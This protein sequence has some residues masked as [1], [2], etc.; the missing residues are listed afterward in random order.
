M[1]APILTAFN[2]QIKTP[3]RGGYTSEAQLTE[4]RIECREE[5]EDCPFRLI[6]KNDTLPPFQFI[7]PG[8]MLGITSW[9]LY[10]GPGSGAT[11]VVDLTSQI[12]SLIKYFQTS[13]SNGFRKDYVYYLGGLLDAV[14]A[15]GTYYMRIVSG[16]VTYLW[17]PIT[18]VCEV[19]TENVLPDLLAGPFQSE[20]NP[21]GPWIYMGDRNLVAI[22]A[23]PGTPSNPAW[24]F[25]GSNV[26]NIGDDSL[27]QYTGGSWFQDLS[28]AAGE[29]FDLSSGNFYKFETTWQGIPPPVYFSGGSMC[30]RGT[31]DFP[32]GYDL[33]LFECLEEIGRF[34]VTVQG[35]EAGSVLVEINDTGGGNVTINADG[36]HS[37]TSYVGNG[38]LLEFNPSGGFDACVTAIEGFCTAEMNQCFYRLDWSNCGSIG[39]TFGGDRFTHSMYFEQAVYPVRPA[40]EVTVESKARNDG[41]KLE[42]RRRRETTWMLDL[43]LVPWFLADALADLPLYDAVV[44]NP[45]GGGQDRLSLVRVS[46]EADEEFAECFHR[47]VITFQNESATSAC[48]DDFDPPCRTSCVEARGFTSHP[49]PE[50]GLNYLV[51][52]QPAYAFYF[53]DT[54]G[55]PAECTSGLAD[56]SDGVDV[57][58]TA[59]FDINEDAWSPVATMIDLMVYVEG[60]SCSINIIALV[61]FP[62]RGILQYKNTLGSWVDDDQYDLGVD[63]WLDNN[64]QRATPLDEH[65][66]KEL[67]IMVYI[68][69][70]ELGHSEVFTYACE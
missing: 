28:P 62:Y 15:S 12:T 66:D 27:Y 20:V 51:I 38:Y 40:P 6:W 60:D 70:C 52:G 24:E 23:T 33:S 22:T 41:S 39:N 25:E 59:I 54:F 34:E 21:D 8:S 48:C 56:I 36:T 47:V 65:E 1:P 45:V 30:F 10:D 35:I 50:N 18:I 49:T 16:G 5:M 37:F 2:G 57:L 63:E 55:T 13:D 17:E 14:L 7:R 44:L 42:T 29:W 9:G 69:D 61:A 4:N 67:R 26:A 64:I 19:Y 31:Y 11:L 58:Y 46:V 43:G 68:G 3:W 32:I 53:D